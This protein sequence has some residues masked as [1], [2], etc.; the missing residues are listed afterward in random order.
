MSLCYMCKVWIYVCVHA[1][2]S[3]LGELCMGDGGKNR[4]VVGAGQVLLRGW[5]EKS[6]CR[7]TQKQNKT[8]LGQQREKLFKIAGCSCWQLPARCEQVTCAGVSGTFSLLL[9]R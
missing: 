3:K 6:V 8:K 4:V 9:L 7:P 1:L 5:L 2:A